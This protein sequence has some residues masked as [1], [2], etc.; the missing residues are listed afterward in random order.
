MIRSYRVACPAN[1]GKLDQVAAL[2]RPWRDGL[3]LAGSAYR[4]VVFAGGRLGWLDAKGFPG[5]LS[6][7]QWDS[8]A[9]Q[10]KAAYVSWVGNLQRRFQR[11]VVRSRLGPVMK[12]EL[13]YIGKARAWYATGLV[14]SST[15][16]TTAEALA[17]ARSIVKHVRKTCPPPRLDR[18]RTMQMDGKIALVRPGLNT[19]DWWARVSTLDRGH[20]VMIP[21]KSNPHLDKALSRPD[22]VLANHLAVH[23]GQDGKAHMSVVVK[24]PDAPLR[25]TGDVVGLD[26]GLVCLFSTSDGALLG[27]RLYS[28]LQK[29]DRELTTLQAALQRSGV[30]PRQSRRYRALSRRIADYVANETNRI[31]N[32]LADQDIKALV[33]EDLDFRHGGLSRSLNRLVNRAGRASVR[34]K[35]ADL[36][37]R[38][39]ISIERVNPA[40]TSQTCPRCGHV[41][42]QNRSQRGLFKCRCCGHSRAADVVAARNIRSRR[43]RP[44]G[45]VTLTRDTIHAT[46]ANEHTHQCHGG[47]GVRNKTT[48]GLHAPR[49]GLSHDRTRTNGNARGSTINPATTT[50]C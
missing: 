26:W 9:A 27:Q 41:A 36:T 8:V 33:V 45:W 1:R 44:H 16:T 46:L 29:R 25:T 17:L 5:P 20:P 21:L 15:H 37:Q 13:L 49:V 12:R 43:S 40:Y 32:R 42:K 23:I 38:C 4:R 7:R 31:L 2:L 24:T 47:C 22:A 30:K 35:L 3:A 50:K 39:G 11:T 18:V 10:A 34:H 19:S 6:Q 28:W 14:L 48:S